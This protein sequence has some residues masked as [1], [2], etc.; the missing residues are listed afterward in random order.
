MLTGLLFDEVG[1]RLT[2]S[3]SSRGPRRYRYYVG[4]K[5]AIGAKRQLRV[6]AAEIERLVISRVSE[7]L[8]D[9]HAVE[10]SFVEHAPDAV[11]IEAVLMV[12]STCAAQLSQRSPANVRELLLEVVTRISLGEGRLTIEVNPFALLDRAGLTASNP[13][14]PVQLQTAFQLI[15]RSKEVRL[16]VAPNRISQ[17]AQ[18]DPALVKLL[19]KAHAARQALLSSNGRSLAEVSEAEGHEPHYF[20]VL[21]KL[22]Y[23]APDITEAILEGRQPAR[24]NRQQLARIRQWPID[25]IEQRALIQGFA[26]I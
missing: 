19:V 14:P 3:H 21:V 20:A 7:W 18:A 26:Q 4:P 23:L 17:G 11:V 6:P 12:A 9:R 15:R 1:E 16:S 5:P 25:W 8:L 10:G 2:P 22:S 24:L 13:V